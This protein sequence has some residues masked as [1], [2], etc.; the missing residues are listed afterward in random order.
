MTVLKCQVSGRTL[1]LTK[2]IASSGEGTVWKTSCRGFLAKLYHERK[3]ERFQKLRVMI[4]HP[5]EDPTRGQNHISLAWPKD[6]LENQ[7][8]QPMGFLMPEIDE[9]VKLSTMYNP[10][11]RSRKAPRF[12][13]YY[14]HTAA[15][16]IAS[17]MNA[18]H[19]EGYV[20]GD[21]KPQNILVNNQA[22]I[23]IIDTDSFQVQDPHTREVF[24][25]WVGSEGFTPAELLG[26]DLAT[27]DQTE[28]HDRFRLGVI[29]FL[30][31][32]G[33]QPFKGKWIGQ[34]ESPQPTTLIEKGFWPY[35]PQSLIRPGPNT[36][37]LS[38]LHPQ[39][40]SCFH[41]CFTQGHGQPHLRPSAQQWMTAL[42]KA[43]ES[44]KTCHLESN[45]H[46]SQSYGHCYW[47]D[48]KSRL[49]VDIFSPAPVISKPAVRPTHSKK[50]NP[51]TA[52]PGIASPTLAAAYAQRMQQ[53]QSMKI[54]N[55]GVT[56]SILQMPFAQRSSW[57]PSISNSVLGLVLCGF[58]FLGLGLLLAP[59]LNPQTFTYWSQSL[60]RAVDQWLA[61]KLGIALQGAPSNQTLPGQANS[62]S[63]LGDPSI[64]QR[65]HLDTVTTL[66]ISPDGQILVSGS[67][68]FTLKIWNL[69]TGKLLNTLSEHYEPI[70]SG[71]FVDGGR[72]LVSSS[73]SGKVLQWDL[74]SA[75][76]IRSFVNY[77]AIR[78]EGG[79]RTTVIDPE[80]HVMA[81]SAWGGSIFLYNLKTDKVTRIPSQL[82]ASEQAMVM[83]PD[84]NTL[85]TSNSDGQI[86]QWNV[87]TG[88]LLKRLPNS[89]GWQSSELTSALVLSGRGK[90][91]IT[92]SWGGK[93]GL[94]NFQTGK[95]LKTF[96]AHEKMVSSLVVSVDNQVLISGGDDQTIKI[97]DLNTGQLLQT[98]TDH[99]GSISA[100]AISPN[101]KWLV[102]GSSDRSIKIWNLQTG[103]LL[104]TLLSSEI[105]KS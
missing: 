42:K 48:R 59:E 54:P 27:I 24:R 7:K 40:Q 11:L 28:I 14:L 22:L 58:S 43:I 47:C 100:L 81:S 36:I 77:T 38:I 84:A 85:V 78:P 39:L 65:G 83:S 19:T 60:E 56:R 70:V 46:Y 53:L 75:K 82:M 105:G 90:T 92:G 37:P 68:D 44:L 103:K 8:G 16:N 93:I 66:A 97:W 86:Q 21:V 10:R 98:L 33:D 67:R 64:P 57:P 6:L 26:K 94:W 51:W 55:A 20:V 17:S 5:P 80:T 15:L 2:K 41:Q 3:S 88:K 30:L 72:S 101:N 23:S 73:V 89:Q 99:R 69:R 95:L 62:A 25:C 104:R 12:N 76:L 31:L 34:G 45:H 63:A 18:V 79:I 102:S 29:I 35:A 49:G 71:H 13:W 32:F 87:N 9:S 91:L 50:V 52:K 96:K 4:A 1:S 61:S 74:P